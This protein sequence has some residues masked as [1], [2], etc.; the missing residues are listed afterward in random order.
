MVNTVSES[1]GNVGK[2]CILDEHELRAD[3]VISRKQKNYGVKIN[4]VGIP[5]I[6]ARS[7]LF[8][9]SNSD[10]DE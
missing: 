2:E 4:C 1:D 8:I 9:L 6:S 10:Q 7:S 3:S 5:Y